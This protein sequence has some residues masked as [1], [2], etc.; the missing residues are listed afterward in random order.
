[1]PPQFLPLDIEPLAPDGRWKASIPYL[2]W[3]FV[4]LGAIVRLVGYLLR[5]PLWVDECML[6]ENFLDRGFAD[7]LAPL[8]NHQAAPIGF[9]WIE[10]ACV[11]I[12]GFSEWSLRLFPLVCGIASLFVFRHLASRLLAGVPL[13]LAVGSL[14]V[15]KSPIGLSANAKPYATDLLAAAVL[16]ALAVEWLRRPERTAWLWTL[17]AVI[18]AVLMLSFP[19]VFVAVAISAALFLPIDRR[20]DSGTWRAYFAYNV[21]LCGGFAVN[22]ALTSG[23][24]FHANRA[25]LGDYWAKCGGF[26]PLGQA[27]LLPAW[28]IDVHLGDRIFCIPYGAENGGGIVSFVCCVVGAA[29]VYRRGNRHILAMLAAIFGLTLVAAA[30]HQYPYGGHNRLM[31]F[32]TPAICL[33]AGLGAAALLGRIAQPVARLRLTGGL[34]LG[35]ALFG[36]G[37]CLRDVQHPYHYELDERHR[38]F[39]RRFWQEER[40]T[41]T[42]CSLTDLGHD[43][44]PGGW[45]AYYRCNQHIYSDRIRAGRRLP[46]GALELLRRPVRLVLYEVHYEPLDLWAVADCLK[47][48]ERC[49]E[50]TS[51]ETFRLPATDEGF[52]HYGRYHVFRFVP[53]RQLAIGRFGDPARIPSRQ[54]TIER[55]AAAVAAMLAGRRSISAPFGIIPVPAGSRP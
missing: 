51:V 32:L 2:V 35:L 42:V 4:F 26:P 27:E 15:A 37:I 14:A 23:L 10:L 18:P 55:P 7:L 13:V 38:E 48:F 40:G 20:R 54:Q 6:A 9:L 19:A 29:V 50:F 11:K 5:F 52:E 34:V 43:F 44:C 49:F 33:G 17:A 30:L 47:Q 1:M 3:G 22:M 41:V 31:Q 28:L 8:A 16:L 39:A 25:F 36:I 46:A 53:R 45:Y 24:D 21:L 12:F